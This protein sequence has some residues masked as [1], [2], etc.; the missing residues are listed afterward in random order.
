MQKDTLPTIAAITFLICLTFP[1]ILVGIA[2][3]G[4]M[5]VRLPENNIEHNYVTEKFWEPILSECLVFYYGCPNLTN[6]T[7]INPSIITDNYL[8]TSPQVDPVAVPTSPPPTAGLSKEK[9]GKAQRTGG[10][11]ARSRNLQQHDCYHH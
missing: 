1:V 7:F 9:E 5:R 6:V 11:C 2:V 3:G 10:C 8:P 4:L